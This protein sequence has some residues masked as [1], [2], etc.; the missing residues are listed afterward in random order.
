MTKGGKLYM[1]LN[2]IKSIKERVNLRTLLI[3]LGIAITGIGFLWISANDNWW[4]SCKVWQTVLQ[5]IG[6]LLVVTVVI[7]L[8][9]ELYGKRAF[10]D[11]VLAKAQISKE[12][13]FA[14]ITK[15]TD[16]FHRQDIDWKKYF[17]TVNKLDIFFAYG[18][19]WRNVHA[20]EFRKIAAREEVR[21]RIVLPDPEDKQVM[22]ELARRFKYTD[23]EIKTIIR[24]AEAYFRNLIN[25]AGANGAQIDI[26]FLPAAPLF[27]FYR[28]D[29]VGIL[30]LYTHR[31]DRAAVPTF[32]CEMGGTLYDYIYKEFKA[33]IKEN[34]L[35]RCVTKEEN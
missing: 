8:L 3:A 1:A 12:L 29:H 20:E 17:H 7:S 6:A 33:M 9:W 2:D 16:T 19:T 18:R 28:F 4:K 23:N 27:S 34:G 31:R 35:A 14:G 15:I 25:S 21:I 24:E 30:A 32:V 5:N 10:L 26:W 22:A 11:E 13:T